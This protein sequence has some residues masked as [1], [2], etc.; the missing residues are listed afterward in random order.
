MLLP[1]YTLNIFISTNS[2]LQES[3]K[4][5]HAEQNTAEKNKFN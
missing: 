3:S 4:N 2:K 5:S 1:V